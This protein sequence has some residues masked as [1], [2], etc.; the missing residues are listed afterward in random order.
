MTFEQQMWAK[1]NEDDEENKY[2]NLRPTNS[3][4]ELAGDKTDETEEYKNRK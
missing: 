2:A 3:Y 4:I 1:W